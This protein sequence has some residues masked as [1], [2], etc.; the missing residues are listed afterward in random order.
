MARSN[1]YARNFK[2]HQRT[3]FFIFPNHFPRSQCAMQIALHF[4][5]TNEN[6][7]RKTN[8]LG[9]MGLR[10][11]F[12]LWVTEC[13][14][15]TNQKEHMCMHTLTSQKHEKKREKRD[16]EDCKLEFQ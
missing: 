6:W 11:T 7:Y 9:K 1:S 10:Q 12:R 4:Y 15:T 8:D 13:P 3:A 5:N 16:A 2:T 14:F